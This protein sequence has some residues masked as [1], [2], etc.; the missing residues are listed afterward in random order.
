[1]PENKL[2]I[3]AKGVGYIISPFAGATIG[4]MALPALHYTIDSLIKQK[5]KSDPDFALTAAVGLFSGL[6]AGPVLYVMYVF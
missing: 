5:Y 2:T 4:A 3:F 6:I 1:M